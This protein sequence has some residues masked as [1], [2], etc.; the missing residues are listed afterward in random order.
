MIEPFK[1]QIRFS[2]CDMMGHV[3]NAVY[4]SYVEM[5]RIHY[6]TYLFGKDRD[7]KK[8]GILVRKNEIEYI[9]PVLFR[10]EATIKVFTTHIGNSSFVMAYEL[11]VGSEIYTKAESVLVY[12]N[13][14][15]QKSAPIPE[16][17]KVELE[18]LYK[19]NL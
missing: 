2:D 1:I 5:A 10:D 18:K 13:S 15:T 16:E 14:E 6:F 19:S 7:W 4:L 9:K 11:H 8:N 17:F 3:N 12:F